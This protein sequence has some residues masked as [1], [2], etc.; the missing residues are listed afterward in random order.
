MRFLPRLI[1]IIAGLAGCDS[2]QP[3]S[4]HYISSGSTGST[5]QNWHCP[6]EHFETLRAVRDNTAPNGG[7]T[8]KV[9]SVL[10]ELAIDALCAASPDAALC[11]ARGPV[12]AYGGYYL[13]RHLM[14][15]VAALRSEMYARSRTLHDRDQSSADIRALGKLLDLLEPDLLGCG[16]MG[17]RTWCTVSENDVRVVPSHRY[18]VAHLASEILRLIVECDRSVGGCSARD[19]RFNSRVALW[20]DLLLWDHVL[21]EASAI[22]NSFT[23]R[24]T[25]FARFDQRLRQLRGAVAAGHRNQTQ[26]RFQAEGRVIAV[27]ANLV[28][29][30]KIL[31]G[32]TDPRL[33]ALTPHQRTSLIDFVG[34]GVDA[35]SERLSPTEVYDFAAEL[36]EGAV[37]DA[38]GWDLHPYRQFSA[39]T[40]AHRPFEVDI[41]A[42]TGGPQ[43]RANAAAPATARG[44][45]LDSGHYRRLVWLYYTLEQAGD[46][47]E[48]SWVERD[49]MKLLANQFAYAVYLHRCH[50]G[51]CRAGEPGPPRF[52]NYASGINGWYRLTPQTPCEPGVPPSGFSTQMLLS[53]NLWWARFNPDV[54]RIWAHLDSALADAQLDPPSSGD[55][56]PCGRHVGTRVWHQTY[57]EV[58]S[59]DT[60]QDRYY[61]AAYSAMARW[62]SLELGDG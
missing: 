29:I 46:T 53:E 23:R 36:A 2:E 45:G 8:P 20:Y 33:Q 30:D 34:L 41:D 5:D 4:T 51:Q 28:A 21:L 31:K 13:A 44:S 42:D 16:R 15:Q 49:T 37:F 19:S 3:R 56:T 32:D 24:W 6:T 9:D 12:G 52:A 50:D 1:I 40:A 61:M 17:I 26:F 48:H 55:V 58:A 25:S 27:A 39:H 14:P 60:R 11:G 43:V 22:R 47:A 35:L 62:A 54:R 18:A 57:F 38:Y 7:T 59:S 10:C